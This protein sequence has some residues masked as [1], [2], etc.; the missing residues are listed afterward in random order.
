MAPRVGFAK[1]RVQP[2][3]KYTYSHTHTSKIEVLAKENPSPVMFETIYIASCNEQ[4]L[5]RKRTLHTSWQMFE[6]WG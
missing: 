5:D 2:R 3:E 1:T 4:I 6:V